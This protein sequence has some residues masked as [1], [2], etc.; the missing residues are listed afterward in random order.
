[1]GVTI[2]KTPFRSPQTNAYCEQLVKTV[3]RNCLDFLIPINEHHLK[4]ILKEYQTHY[5]QGR[6]HSS[7]GPKLLETRPGLPVP[8]Q[9]Q[10]HQIPIKY[11]VKSKP[12]LNSLHRKY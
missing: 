7:L 3:R 9:K 4:T 1:M 6:P 12:I 8:L 11:R 5:N 10:R 2:L